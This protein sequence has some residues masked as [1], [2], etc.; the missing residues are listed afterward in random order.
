[1]C[2]F[3]IILFVFVIALIGP[4][5]V[6]SQQG[7]LN[8][9]RGINDDL[10]G[11]LDEYGST[12]HVSIQPWLKKEIPGADA[13]DS[14]YGLKSKPEKKLLFSFLNHHVLDVR[15]KK[16]HFVMDP[17][18]DLSAGFA[19]SGSKIYDGGS[20]GLNLTADFGK[21]FTVGGYGRFNQYSFPW[22]ID[23]QIKTTRV[24]P[25][26]GYAR[27]SSLGGYYSWD[28]DFYAN[29]EFLKYFNIE[30]GVGRNFWGDGYRSMFLSDNAFS[31][32]YIKITTTV[33]HIKYVN[34]WAEFKDMRN[35]SS[36]LW[37]N[38][39]NKYGS[40]HYL[41]WNI[42]KRV[43]LGFF[44]A[45]IWQQ[46]DSATNRGFDVNYINP[47][48]FLRPVE[49]S[50]GSPDN[51]MI[52]LSLKVK[53]A[54]KNVFYGQFLIDDIIVSEFTHGSLNRIKHW[55]GND[56]STNQYGY[57]TNKQAWQI[58]FRSYDLFRVKNFDLQAE[59]NF[60]RP[61][62]YSHRIV[63]ENYGHYNEPLAHPLGAN[64]TEM[65]GFL[66]YNMGRWFF[67]GQAEYIIT[68]LDTTGTH[69]GQDIFQSTFDT[70]YPE[71]GNIP[72]QQYGNNI[73][74]GIKTH[75]LYGALRAAWLVNPSMNLRVEAELA[76]RRQS[77]VLETKSGIF[78]TAGIKTSWYN[79]RMDY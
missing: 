76:Y 11:G 35:T 77:S 26:V 36:G 54:K 42:S 29:Y 33:W 24:I 52:G 43:N 66:R 31:Y 32:P 51:S 9:Y 79:R 68:G 62:T 44:E 60:A 46:G 2:K 71:V 12:M 17:L 55:F 38:M 45:V 23:Q 34:L 59:F 5:H 50:V 49:F 22:N 1:M 56:D 65:L 19:S 20:L 72:V 78:I 21:R 63:K 74:Q 30:A 27:P 3:K 25:G 61:Y 57:W 4:L 37:S 8:A 40:F 10:W 7:H 15:K 6:F 53:V 14:L 18:V 64:F 39:D 67:E 75:I 58:G 13:L 47:F 28:M 70:Y 48:I 16:T 69:Y 73:G 41:S